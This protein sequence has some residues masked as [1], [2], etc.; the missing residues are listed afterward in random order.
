MTQPDKLM[1]EYVAKAIELVEL[2]CN[3][4]DVRLS[5]EFCLKLSE[6]AINAL[7]SYKDSIND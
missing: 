2:K 7:N 1:I 5:H 3:I 6:A 4:P